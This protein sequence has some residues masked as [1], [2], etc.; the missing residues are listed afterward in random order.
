MPH[1]SIFKVFIDVNVLLDFMAPALAE[2]APGRSVLSVRLE[3][4]LMQ[5][6]LFVQI[7]LRIP[8]APVNAEA[9]R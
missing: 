4:I 7:A 5:A 3:S 9:R 6:P 2:L 8:S 1:A